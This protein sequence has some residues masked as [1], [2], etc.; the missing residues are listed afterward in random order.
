MKELT[1]R[2]TQERIYNILEQFAT[3]CDKHQLEY[4]LCGGTM[5]GAIRHQGFIPWDDDID[6][7][8]P[9]PDY[10]RLLELS[11]NETVGDAMVLYAYEKGNLN[12]PFAKLLDINTRI[13]NTFVENDGSESL[14]IDILPVDGLPLDASELSQHYKKIAFYRRLLMI[15]L[16]KF[17]TGTSLTK[18]LVKLVLAPMLRIIKPSWYCDKINQL[19]QK[20]DYQTNQQVGVVSWGLYGVAE[21]MPKKDYQEFVYKTFEQGRFKAPRGWDSYLTSLYKDYMKLPPE[22]K[23]KTH[24]SK[25]WVTEANFKG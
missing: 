1:I 5:L 12:Y 11:K 15:S 10:N 24:I 13:E 18:K 2:E 9:R 20:Y 19:A 4:R 25:V 16:S 7:S 8:M 17:G 14:W 3:F 6:I 21:S 23:R 22:D